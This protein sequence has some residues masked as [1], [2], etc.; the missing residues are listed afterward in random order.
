MLL[1]EEAYKKIDE[2]VKKYPINKQ[3]SAV[4]AALAIAQEEKKWLSPEIQKDIANY[5]NIPPI[6]VYEIATFY[7]MFHTNPV[8]KYTITICTNLPC[9]LAGSLKSM[10]Y[11]IQK[12]NINFPKQ[13]TTNDYFFTL[14]ESECMGA[15][16]D[17]PVI[18]INNKRM[19]S[20]MSIKKIDIL[21]KELKS[22]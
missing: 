12:L 2:E 3:K 15:C 20:Y 5:L 21:L 19:C 17:A 6:A 18:L 9:I 11:L 22:L 7:S 14:I 13:I 4:I 1:S 10:K 16:G 8:G